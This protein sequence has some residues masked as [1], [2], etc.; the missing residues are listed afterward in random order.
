MSLLEEYQQHIENK[1]PSCYVSLPSQKEIYFSN[2]EGFIRK[3]LSQGWE[4][5]DLF[6]KQVKNGNLFYVRKMLNDFRIDPT[7]C[8]HE[9]IILSVLHQHYSIFD[10]LYLDERIDLTA[11]G[12]LPY[13]L[14]IRYSDLYIKQKLE[15][16]T[17]VI[18]SI[19]G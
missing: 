14:A 15:Q 16:H 3:K 19:M 18:A 5:H 10:L 4:I 13:L 11:Q 9:C 12:N 8:N 7:Y 2:Y 17:K 6:L 1:S